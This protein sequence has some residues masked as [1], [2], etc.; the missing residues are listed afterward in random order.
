VTDVYHGVAVTDAY[1]WLEDTQS[2]EVKSWVGAQNARSRHFLDALPQRAGVKKEIESMMGSGHVSRRYFT[3]TGG[4]L[5]AM[6]EQSPKNQRMLVLLDS[7]SNVRAERTIIDPNLIDPRG[8]T[9]IDWY[10]PSQD[11][12]LVAASL[13]E[14][15][16]E[17]GTVY[18][19][20]VATGKRLADVVPRAQYPTGGGSLVWSPDNAGFLYTRYPQ[21]TERAK[22]DRN[23]FQQVYFHRLGTPASSDRYVIGAEFPRV[24]EIALQSSDDGQ[25][26]L[27]DVANGDGGEHAF[28]LRHKDGHWTRLADFKDGFRNAVFGR[29]GRI[30]V[31]ASAGSPRGQIAA[32]DPAGLLEGFS[33][34][35]IIIP[36]SEE[37]IERVVAGQSRVYVEYLAGGPTEIRM[38]GQDGRYYGRL[39]S[40]PIGSAEI[41][42]VLQKDALL[43]GNESYTRA[44]AWYVFEGGDVAIKPVRTHL[45]DEPVYTQDGELRDA[46]AV[47]EFAT[48]AD[49]TRIPMTLI[50]PAGMNLDGSHPTLLTAYGGYGISLSPRFSRDVA[51]WVRHG[52]VFAVAN[53]RGG[54]ELGEEWHRAGYLTHKQNVFEDFIA[55][56]TH[57]VERGYT[58]K[59]RLAI[60]GGSNGGLLMGAVTVQRPELFRAVVSDVG[61][62][63]MLRVERTPNGAFNVTEY[64]SVEDAL[65]FEA[66]YAYSPFHHVIDGTHYPAMLLTTGEHDGRVAPWMSYKM[67]AR[68]QAAD[69]VG[70]PI[71]LR[72]AADEGHGIGTSLSARIEESADAFAFLF[73][74]LQMR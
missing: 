20:E 24:A 23:F 58:S 29:D 14:N 35:R 3:Y 55:C 50:Y 70:Q 33:D 10:V 27:A 4:H 5:F 57:L 19:Y 46:E 40:L 47:R 12:H 2:P 48:S 9:T 42:C 72:V 13:S 31:V 25:Y 18:V 64:G 7:P 39:G 66:L 44:F 38:F 60:R 59:R 67:A 41:G 54:G 32:F 22:E 26:V 1:Q 56:A 63:D 74:E 30:Y 61:I 51:L 8:R 6:K 68:L 45:S 71:L 43:F 69:P 16:S 62:Y 49:G 34:A 37:V 73:E 21:G 53:L 36:E 15:G 65:Q 52:G 28:Y 17:D 11:G